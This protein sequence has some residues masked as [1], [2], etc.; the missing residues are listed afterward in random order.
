[1][2]RRLLGALVV[3]L[4]L[5]AP[6]AGGGP[7]MLLGVAEDSV[8][9]TDPLVVRGRLALLRLAG[10]DSV[11]VSSNWTPG[12]VAPTP[13]EL[14]IL[15]NVAF[16]AELTGIRVVLSVY[17]P[18][19][20]TTPVTPEAR[21]QFAAYVA[22]LAAALPAVRDVVV[23]NEPNL[24]RF[25][26]PQFAADG[27]IASAPAYL[28]LLARAYDAVKAVDPEVTVWGGALAPRGND[29]PGG[30]RPTVSPTAFIRSLGRAYRASGRPAPIMDGLALHPYAGTSSTPPERSNRG[31]STIGLADYTRLVTLLGQAF[32]GTPQEGSTLPILYSEFGVE[33]LVPDGK[34]ASYS[35]SEPATTRPV[36]EAL[37]ASYYARAVAMAF[38]QPTVAGILLFH[39]HDEPGLANWQSGLFYAD[40]APKAGVAFVRD[41]LARAR[42]G[43]IARCRELELSPQTTAL[44]FATSRA[45]VTARLRCDLDCSILA[46]LERLPAGKPVRT[47]RQW[48]RA[49]TSATIVVPRRGIPR[50][51]YVLTLE[52]TQ[53]VNPGTP[54]IVESRPLTLG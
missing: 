28:D 26:L 5:A 16:A 47:R 12:E 27:T 41:A 24:N 35:G 54:T 33:S 14:R 40:G 18:G 51:R 38:C 1:M 11:R 42:G 19:S 32:D 23:G 34:A 13:L 4:A 36:A 30:I 3:A 50:G 20:R 21:A 37:Q 29:R 48:A 45:E 53:P 43:S 10:F 52:L 22:A 9:S 31:T 44:S 46:R 25:W 2:T 17:Q 49:G 39:S 8:R 15:G 6:A 7:A